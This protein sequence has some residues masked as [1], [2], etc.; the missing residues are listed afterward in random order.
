MK[1]I[2]MSDN[3]NHFVV[4]S[5][6]VMMLLSNIG[7][8]S[9]ESVTIPGYT[10]ELG[11]E[12]VYRSEKTAMTDMTMWFDEPAAQR[13]NNGYFRHSVTIA[14]KSPESMLQEWKL[15]ADLPPDISGTFEM[16][17]MYR[18]TQAAY[19]V[20]E[21]TIAADLNGNPIDLPDKDKILANVKKAAASGPGGEPSPDSALAG[22]VQ[23]LEQ[24]PLAVIEAL[25]PEAMYL[26]IAQSSE[27]ATYDVGQSWELSQEEVVNGVVVPVKSNWRVEST[28]PVKQTVTLSWKQVN[29]PVVLAK[30]Q[31]STIEKFMI[32]FSERMK[33]LTVEQLAYARTASKVREGSAVISLRNGAS[34]EVTEIATVT[35][36]GV[37]I[38]SNVHIFREN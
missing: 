17:H 1:F 12:Q 33:T 35:T 38:V 19:G 9:A 23:M 37:K 14:S 29:D 36:G 26:A 24:N 18:A 13:T 15:S 34:L 5:V 22:I 27:G 6:I 28:D 31:L 4:S 25:V 16:N 8:A 21:L 11:V 32:S 10:P 30:V 3:K 20:E 7:V 2:R